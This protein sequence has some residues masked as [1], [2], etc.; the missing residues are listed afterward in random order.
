[1]RNFNF[2]MNDRDHNDE[3]ISFTTFPEC[4]ES[5]LVEADHEY[6]IMINGKMRT[7]ISFGL[8]I[9]EI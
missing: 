2:S 1:M 3:S 4:D 5:F 8:D 9:L 7:K 6:P